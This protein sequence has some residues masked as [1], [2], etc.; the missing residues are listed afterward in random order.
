LKT[1]Q[2]TAALIAL[3]ITAVIS[4]AGVLTARF[5]DRR[6][7]HVLAPIPFPHKDEGIALQKLAFNQPDLLP[8]LRQ[9]GVGQA[10]QQKAHRF[11][12]GLS[13]GF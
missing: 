10:L 9:L 5:L 11:F 4:C 3:G 8:D 6:Y 1:P 7:I 13:D 12:P 2:L